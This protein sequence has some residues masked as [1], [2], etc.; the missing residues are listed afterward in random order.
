[1]DRA[2]Q[3]ATIT[4]P[5]FSMTS[6]PRRRELLTIALGVSV[7]VNADFDDDRNSL[8]VSCSGRGKVAIPLERVI[9][10][11]CRDAATHQALFSPLA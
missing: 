6:L 2:R 8:V 7:Y 5:V 1:M 10:E 4:V 9:K 11:L 3:L